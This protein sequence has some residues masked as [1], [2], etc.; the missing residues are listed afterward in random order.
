M[1]TLPFPIDGTVYDTDGTTALASVKVTIRNERTNETLSDTTDSAGAYTLDCA[2]L[3]SQ[4]ANGDTISIFVIYTTYEDYEERVI[5]VDDGGLT[6]NLTLTA[7]PASDSLKYFTVQSFFDYFNLTAGDEGVPLT[8]QIV[9][10]GT[11]VE[12]DIDDICQSEFSTSTTITQEYHDVEDFQDDWFLEKT[13]VLSVTT[14]QVNTAEDGTADSWV[15]LTEAAY[16]FEISLDTGRIRLTG[17]VDDETTPAYPES[18]I[19]QMRVTYTYGKT[20]V[21]GDIKQLAILMTAAE[22]AKA[23]VGRALFRGQDSFKTDHYNVF[24]KKI[25][26]ILAKYRK[27][28]MFNT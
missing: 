14:L 4:Y 1:A 18:G 15:T 2:N 21:P 11:M 7:V 16:Q 22:F 20:S 24:D 23:A 10:T 19:K 5:D 26:K 12:A 25:D 6:V 28:D 9:S 3:A 8:N 27:I 13:P 17:K